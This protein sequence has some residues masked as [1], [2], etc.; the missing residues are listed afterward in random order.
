MNAAKPRQVARYR[1]ERSQSAE[2]G[3]SK[4]GLKSSLGR[5]FHSPFTAAPAVQRYLQRW[6]RCF[7]MARQSS[8]GTIR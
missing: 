8:P 5:F 4:K 1:R 3:K 6:C 7:A 2:K